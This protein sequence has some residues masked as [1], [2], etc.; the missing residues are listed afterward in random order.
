M[1]PTIHTAGYRYHGLP[2]TYEIVETEDVDGFAHLVQ[3]PQFG[4]G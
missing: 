1:S 2:H 3:S 4:G